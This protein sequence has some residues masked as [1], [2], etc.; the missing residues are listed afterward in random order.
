MAKYFKAPN[1]KDYIP[2]PVWEGHEAYLD[3]YHKA[4]ELARAHVKDL[5]GM[6]QTPY[7]D[8]AFC[9]T[10][11]WIWDT[12]FMS[13]FCKYAQQVFPGVESLNNFYKPLYEGEH[14]ATVIP[15]ESEP[16]WT[17]AVPG[18]P[19]EVQVHIADN[20]PL[21]AWA[22]YENL[23]LHGDREYLKQLLYERGFLQ[24]H[25]EWLE[26][27]HETALGG[28]ITIPT[29]WKS[30]ECGYKWEGGRSGMD[31]T[32]RGRTGE[33]AQAVRPNN[34]DMLWID[35]ICQQ[36]LS[37]KTIATMFGILGDTAQKEAWMAK[38][39]QKKDL[40]NRLYWDEE[41]AFYYDIDCNTHAPYKVRSIASYWTLTAGIAT[42]ERALAMAAKLEDPKTFGG[43][44]PFPS[45]S[46]DDNDFS[47][48]GTY[49]RGGVWLPTVYATLKGLAN[50][51]LYDVA[52]RTATK[53]L[54]HMLHTYEEYE[55]HT[56]WEA[57][58]P[59]ACTPGTQIDGKE[60]VRGDFCGW[61]ALGPISIYIEF[62][63]GFHTVDALQKLVVWDRDTTVCQEN[64][65]RNLRFGNIVTDI[66][67]DGKVCHVTSNASY[68]LQ[69][70][71]KRFEVRPGEN[72][73]S[74]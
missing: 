70:N 42:K 55:P 38:F 48:T 47:P 44:V 56:L 15:D 43:L 66:L 34:P 20:P 35:A 4:W 10:Q 12:C 68:T 30:E 18:K 27:L 22:E 63:L 11:I 39:E 24:K 59:N 2:T 41:D 29:F 21:F 13:L 37:A 31:N 36:A 1:W 49:W 69:L 3:L 58:A 60:I 53:L 54:D 6:A 64:G 50:Y 57:Y 74:L 65:I 72:C 23:L 25:Y 33:H 40:V 7:M 32:P 51:G 61:S 73:F 19:F 26:G 46:R 17:G 71:G 5:P 28:A 9:A 67:S 62:I 16:S 8:E 14:L 52:R 45:I